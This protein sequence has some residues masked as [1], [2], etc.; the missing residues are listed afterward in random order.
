MKNVSGYLFFTS[1][2]SPPSERK[3]CPR[4]SESESE[5]ESSSSANAKQP[6]HEAEEKRDTHRDPT[7]TTDSS[8]ADSD[9]PSSFGDSG[10]YIGK[11]A[12]RGEINMVSGG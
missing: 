7:G 12:S 8:P 3:S 4:K 11:L 6:P 2:Y 1:E 10:G 5:S 9:N